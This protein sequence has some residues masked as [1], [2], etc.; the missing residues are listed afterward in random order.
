MSL[1]DIRN[2]VTCIPLQ[3]MGTI[4]TFVLAARILTLSSPTDG[5]PCLRLCFSSVP[6]FASSMLYQGLIMHVGATGG[7]LYL[8]FFYS[9]L[10]EFPAAFIILATIDRFGLIRPLAT[11]NLMAGVACFA[12]IFISHGESCIPLIF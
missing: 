5:S 4:G 1:Q 9:A 11:S 6:R 7:N 10:V 2:R 3:L 12:M 8:D